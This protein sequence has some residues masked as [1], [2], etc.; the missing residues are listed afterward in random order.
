[1]NAGWKKT[2]RQG[3]AYLDKNAKKCS[4]ILKN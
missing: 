2:K 1:M 4:K 3:N